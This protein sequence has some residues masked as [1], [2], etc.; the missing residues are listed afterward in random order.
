MT[1]QQL[2]KVNNFITKNLR[3]TDNIQINETQLEALK[4]A[5]IRNEISFNEENIEYVIKESKKLQKVNQMILSN[6]S[7]EELSQ[8]KTVIMFVSCYETLQIKNCDEEKGLGSLSSSDESSMKIYLREI[9]SYP[10]LSKSAE[11]ELIKRLDNNDKDAFTQLYYSNLRLVVSIARRYANRGVD[12]MDLIQEGNLGLMKGIEKFDSTKGTKLS[13][14]ATFWILQSIRRAIK[15]SSRLI[16]ISEHAQG[17][18]QKIKKLEEKG[19]TNKEIAEK[20]G[21]TLEYVQ[22]LIAVSS[23][24]ASI[25]A[26]IEN[27]DNDDAKLIDTI[28]DEYYYFE[29][30]I[31]QCYSCEIVDLALSCNKLDER[32]KYILKKRFGFLGKIYSLEEVGKE[33]GIS[34]QFV[35]QL[36]K[37][38]LNKLRVF[39]K[40]EMITNS[41][42]S[43][44]K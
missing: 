23:T 12:L 32:E 29:D 30:E 24:P 44:H 35:Q 19:Y 17:I 22:Q 10:L 5:F 13:T 11:E 8:N 43:R 28:A 25:D 31:D 9:G 33:L 16:R 20:L 6:I 15:E 36:E 4:A 21:L 40:N 27:G 18:L 39:L 14:Y 2:T 37:R 7:L 3:I 38:A 1:S 42:L 41:V 34:R 26:P